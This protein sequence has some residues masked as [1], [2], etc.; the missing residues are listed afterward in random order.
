MFTFEYLP[1]RGLTKRTL[2][3]YDIKTKIDEEG[4]P[5]STGFKYPDGRYKVRSFDRKEFY[6]STGGTDGLV[7][8]LVAETEAS[9]GTGSTAEVGR[10]SQQSGPGLFGR[11]RFN[12]GESSA[13]I[14]TEGEYDAASLY[15]TLHIPAVSVSSATSA[16]R[17]CSLSRSFLNSFVRIYLAFDNDT[18]GREARQAV[19]RLFD[20]NKLLVLDFDT[21]K[22]ANEFLQ[23]GEE[24]HLLNIFK[25]AKRFLPETVV[26]INPETTAKILA[27]APGLGIPYPF[28][29]LNAM[30][31]GIRKG[32]SV[33]ITAQEG[34]GK[35]EV[36]HAIEHQLLKET[37][38]AIG[39]IFLEEPK[40]VHLRTIAAIELKRPT[41]LPDQGVTEVQIKDAVATACRKSDRL[42]LYNH[43]GSD[44][45]DVFL[46][47][48]RFMVTACNVS[49][50]LLD[51]ISMVVSGITGE[52][53]ERRAFDYLS[54]KLETMVKELNFALIFVSH[55]NDMGQTRGSRYIS[56]IADVRIDI[57]RDL[58]SSN[59]TVRN[60][61]CL[62]VSKC[63]PPMGRT[64]E[65]GKY[66]FDPFTRQYVE[67]ANDNELLSDGGVSSLSTKETPLWAA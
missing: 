15:Q 2:E 7:K 50:V 28:P 26:A 56:K 5:V 55:V 48:I 67:V 23:V 9:Q 33:L 8:D 20:Y 6:W 12:G 3:F 17:D 10:T 31:H 57:T 16:Y 38:D 37:D 21:R 46:D 53:D 32:E 62:A 29:T 22:D 59:D 60:T 44:D 25:N 45:P 11:D 39:S 36:M 54:T 66:L 64:G 13:I 43:F 24:S 51:H 1:H 27:E 41:F 18:H 58:M 34:V 14:I 52:R 61:T 65:A 47:T 40:S 35:T 63:R 4:K 30:T 49:Y 42:H 19:A